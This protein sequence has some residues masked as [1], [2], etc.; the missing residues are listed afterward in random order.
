MDSKKINKPTTLLKK[1]STHIGVIVA[2]I[3]GIGTICGA[4]IAACNWVIDTV[5]AKADARISNLQRELE[6]NDKRQELAMLRLELLSLM[7]HDPT[8]IVEIEKVGRK[9]FSEGGDWYLTGM[10]SEW[11]AKYG[12]D[13]NIVLPYKDSE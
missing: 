9:Y 12:C 1:L 11:C 8:N 10:F 7:S 2:I 13:A 5:N 6:E 3:T 4:G